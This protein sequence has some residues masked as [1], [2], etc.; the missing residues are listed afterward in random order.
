MSHQVLSPLLLE[1]QGIR[2]AIANEKFGAAI[3][4]LPSEVL[5]RRAD[6]RCTWALGARRSTPGRSIHSRVHDQWPVGYRDVCGS[7]G[8]HGRRLRYYSQTAA[9]KAGFLERERLA[10]RDFRFPCRAVF[11]GSNPA[12]RRDFARTGV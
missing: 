7:L 11:V 8:D 3:I 6:E 1:A 9:R 10:Y 2:Y 4:N 5:R 12:H